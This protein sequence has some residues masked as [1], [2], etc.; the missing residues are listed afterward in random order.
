MDHLLGAQLA[1]VGV[2]LCSDVCY[3]L[4]DIPRSA[5][6]SQRLQALLECADGLCSTPVHKRSM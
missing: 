5:L 3:R 2:Y 4:L 1:Q 6:H